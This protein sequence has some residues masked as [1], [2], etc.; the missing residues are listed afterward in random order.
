MTLWS[1]CKYVVDGMHKIQ[2]RPTLPLPKKNRTLWI[3]ARR[4][5]SARTSVFII[6]KV[7]AHATHKDVKDGKLSPWER[8]GNHIADK[9]AGDAAER[10]AIKHKL[11]AKLDL[12]DSQAPDILKRLIAINLD[13]CAKSPRDKGDRTPKPKDPT[14][15]SLDA[16]L[17]ATLADNDHSIVKFKSGHYRCLKCHGYHTKQLAA[18]AFSEPCRGDMAIFERRFGRAEINDSHWLCV[19]RGLAWCNICGGFSTKK[20]AALGRPCK[21][22]KG[23]KRTILNHLREGILPYSLEDWPD[24]KWKSQA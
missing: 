4:M 24:Q 7:L 19:T 3:D 14:G 6:H 9:Y 15:L 20:V 12:I 22:P 5:L 10:Y 18:T 13:I 11:F 1:D 8:L 16:R 21:K 2:F 17:N 23:A